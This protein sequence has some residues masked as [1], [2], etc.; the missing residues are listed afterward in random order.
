MATFCLAMKMTPND[1]RQLTLR[2]RNAFIDAFVERA[3][4]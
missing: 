1:Y 3:G 2:E 4:D